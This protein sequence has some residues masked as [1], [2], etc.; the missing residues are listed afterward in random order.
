MKE[1]VP[2]PAGKLMSPLVFRQVS[3]CILTKMTKVFPKFSQLNFFI[4]M[5]KKC[6]RSV[7]SGSVLKLPRICRV[8]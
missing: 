1:K 3:L 8:M 2:K 6:V 5:L 4:V 7:G